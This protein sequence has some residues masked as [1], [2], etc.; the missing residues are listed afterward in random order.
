MI[1]SSIPTVSAKLGLAL[2]AARLAALDSLLGLV[3]IAGG[4]AGATLFV[5]FAVSQFCELV[6]R[7]L[8]QALAIHLDE[9]MSDELEAPTLRGK[10]RQFRASGALKT[11]SRHRILDHRELKRASEVGGHRYQTAKFLRRASMLAG[12]NLSQVRRAP[13]W[14]NFCVSELSTSAARPWAGPHIARGAS[15]SLGETI[16]IY[17]GQARLPP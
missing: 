3:P 8:G 11:T 12:Y 13:S 16:G 1:R 5:L 7:T 15:E 4:W 6:V 9:P 17:G 2:T 14:P 10:I